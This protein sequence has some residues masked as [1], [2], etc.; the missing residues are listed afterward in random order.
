MN[1]FT[2]FLFYKTETGRSRNYIIMKK[3][4]KTFAF[5]ALISAI[6]SCIFGVLQ[7]TTGEQIFGVLLSYSILPFAIVMSYQILVLSLFGF[8][9]K[10]KNTKNSEKY[11]GYISITFVAL[12]GIPI[13]F[14]MLDRAIGFLN[15]DIFY[16]IR[17]SGRLV[18]NTNM[19]LLMFSIV[20]LFLLVNLVFSNEK[21][22]INKLPLFKEV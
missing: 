4:T 9:L 16:Q 12:I 19:R 15:P 11:I 21:K 6:L 5:T 13:L 14:L 10:D 18:I 3:V 22:I 2:T 7:I 17:E 1:I 8:Q 20:G